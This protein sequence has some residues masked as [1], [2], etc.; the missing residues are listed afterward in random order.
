MDGGGKV[1]VRLEYELFATDFEGKRGEVG[2]DLDI[3]SEE[4]SRSYQ[5]QALESFMRAN[6]VPWKAGPNCF[7]RVSYPDNRDE[8]GN[9]IADVNDSWTFKMDSSTAR[10]NALKYINQDFRE[11]RGE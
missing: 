6:D 5:W 8:N 4:D 2:I 7:M 3:T 10:E 9:K 11:I 1:K